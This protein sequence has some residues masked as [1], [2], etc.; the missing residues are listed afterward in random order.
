ML[1]EVSGNV[2]LNQLEWFNSYQ[3]SHPS[4][5]ILS[6]LSDWSCLRFKLEFK[7][8]LRLKVDI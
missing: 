3:P 8:Y 1:L 2:D 7:P 5:V 4:L 6:N